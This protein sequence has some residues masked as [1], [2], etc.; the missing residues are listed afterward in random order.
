MGE[1]KKD[2]VRG[3]KGTMIHRK[4]RTVKGTDVYHCGHGKKEKEK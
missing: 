1:D 4:P 3:L 2:P